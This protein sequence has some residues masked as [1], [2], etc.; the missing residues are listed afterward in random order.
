MKS[1]AAEVAEE[2]KGLA[3]NHSFTRTTRDVQAIEKAKVL[4]ITSAQNNTEPEWDFFQALLRYCNERQAQ[5]IVRPI[6]YKNPTSRQDPQERADRGDYWW[7]EAFGPYLID[8][9]LVLH[10]SLV[11][12]DMR[13]QATALRP[14]TGLDSRSK[15]AS[16]I[17][18]A[19]QLQMRTV[20]TPQNELPKILYTTGA[21]T[22]KNYSATKQGNLASF[23][24][25]HSAIVVEK[26]GKIFHMREITWDGESF[27]D[28]NHK[29]TAGGT[30]GADPA[31][32]LILGDEHAWFI[33][34]DF[35]KATYGKDGMVEAMQPRVL[36]HHDVFD[37]F[38]VS[39][40]HFKEPMMQTV[41]QRDGHGNL[42]NELE[43]TIRYVDGTT[44]RYDHFEHH[45]IVSSNH[46]D[47]LIRWL[48]SGE[49]NVT[50]E[51]AEL[52]HQLKH[53]ILSGAKMGK[54]R[55]HLPHPLRVFAENRMASPCHFLGDDESYML[56][57]IE[58]GMHGHLG[59]N[60]SRGTPVGL[61][62]IGVRFVSGHTHSPCIFQGGY[63]V[64]TGAH[65]R[66]GYTRGPSSWLH[67]NVALHSNGKRQMHHIIGGNWRI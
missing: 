4:V 40:H 32:A 54:T 48:D 24:H 6:R 26:R 27:I 50:A 58:L 47:H 23:H 28:V 52:Y 59:P 25:S 63:W 14:L 51:N 34:P 39:P 44:P 19:T 36:V 61:S 17:Y 10:P 46:H 9:S 38:S 16:A 55:I 7:H 1:P 37:C 11:M 12:P 43:A 66:L 65:L 64:G 45:V 57:N 41:K 18:G 49:K 35:T 3:K 67:T 29:F 56:R 13:L 20:P 21:A 8:D 2:D 22:K 33:N 60:G 31:E 62:K 30:F 15:G 5:L 53:L 42:R